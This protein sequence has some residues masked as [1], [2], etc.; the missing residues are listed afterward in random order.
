MKIILT[1]NHT[2]ISL[3]SILQ[4]A[5]A[6][7]DGTLQHSLVLLGIWDT[8]FI[9]HCRVFSLMVSGVKPKVAAWNFKDNLSDHG[10][11]TRRLWH[12]GQGWCTARGGH[13]LQGEP[14]SQACY[15]SAFPPLS[16][17]LWSLTRQA[18]LSAHLCSGSS[19][20]PKC[21]AVVRTF[22]FNEQHIKSIEQ[23]LACSKC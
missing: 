11:S 22:F 7:A 20:F 1:I 16:P 18:P 13:L 17:L 14:A 9:T 5:S 10:D 8:C 19:P 6:M 4:L 3:I 12:P 15:D 21:R 23:Y 2:L